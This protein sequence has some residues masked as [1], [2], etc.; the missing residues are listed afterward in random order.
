MTAI[1]TRREAS[2]RLLAALL[3]GAGVAVVVGA[4]GRIHDPTGRELS[5]LF[6]SSTINLKVW[7]ASAAGVI[8]LFQLA[9]ALKLYGVIP[10]RTPEW[11]GRVH[12]NTGRLAFLLTVPVAFHCLWS[13]GFQ[14]AEPRLVVHSLAGC[15]FY[16]A[17]AAKILVVRSRALPGWALPV[18]GGLLFTAITTGIL[19]SALWYYTNVGA[20]GV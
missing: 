18:V 3:L 19:T 13:I 8:A 5:T 2:P 6:F 7:F 10:G 12:R 14:T 16:G 17:F 11:L 15:L 1:D 20:P 4:Y 9:S